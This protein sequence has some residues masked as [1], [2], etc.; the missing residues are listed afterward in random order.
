[1]IGSVLNILKSVH[2]NFFKDYYQETETN[3]E[4]IT[5]IERKIKEIKM[6]NEKEFVTKKKKV[7]EFGFWAMEEEI[8]FEHSWIQSGSW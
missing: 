4:G 3:N 2:L 5:N 1:M 7:I 8:N 6:L